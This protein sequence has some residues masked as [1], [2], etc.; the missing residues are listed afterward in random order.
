M[1]R[2]DDPASAALDTVAPVYGRVTVVL[3]FVVFNRARNRAGF[4]DAFEADPLIDDLEV[5][6]SFIDLHNQGREF[7]VAAEQLGRT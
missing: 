3:D 4:L 5:R 7:V 1:E 2:A 6:T